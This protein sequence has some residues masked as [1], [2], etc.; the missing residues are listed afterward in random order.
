MDLNFEVLKEVEQNFSWL[1]KVRR[2]FLS[3]LRESRD[4]VSDAVNRF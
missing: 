2:A 1:G 3:V 4:L